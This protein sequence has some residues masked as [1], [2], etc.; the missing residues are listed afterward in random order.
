MFR[1]AA[2]AAHLYIPTGPQIQTDDQRVLNKDGTE[3]KML[4]ALTVIL[5]CQLIGELVVGGLGL[6]V[7]GP[8]LGMLVLFNMLMV[9]GGP[10]REFEQTA[11]GLLRHLSLLFVPAGTGVI[12]HFK[13]LGEAILPISLAV[14]VSTF[15]TIAVTAFLMRRLGRDPGQ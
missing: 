2:K 4:G 3:Q 11:N 9:R 7:P 15:L 14:V 12:L 8:V 1:R 13:L 6:P 5:G 10:S